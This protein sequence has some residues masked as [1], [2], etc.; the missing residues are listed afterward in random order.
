[1]TP[2]ES[3]CLDSFPDWLGALSEDARALAALLEG[4]GPEVGRQ[5]AALALTYLLKSLDLIPDGLQDLGLIDDAFVLRVAATRVRAEDRSFDSSG[6]L[7]RL[8]SEAGLL[9]EFL[10]PEYARLERYV[11]KLEAGSARGRGV[12]AVMH[13]PELRAALISDVR[14]W[15][16]DYEPPAFGRD[17]KNLVKLRS[18]LKTRIAAGLGN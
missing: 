2:L 16:E 15:A 4:N 9:A 8:T 7:A 5:A 6:T 12:S 1:M 17:E 13:D 14:R 11:D 3:R 10:G 18:F